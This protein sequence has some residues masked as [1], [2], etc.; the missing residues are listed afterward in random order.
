VAGVAAGQRHGR[1]YNLAETLGWETGIESRPRRYLNDLQR[2]RWQSI[3]AI[4]VVSTEMARERYGNGEFLEWLMQRGMAAAYE[5]YCDLFI[6][7]PAGIIYQL[8]FPRC[9]KTT[10]N[11]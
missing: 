2:G 3:A 11:A 4:S 7:E 5:Q 6:S 1:L 9:P 10:L 8:A